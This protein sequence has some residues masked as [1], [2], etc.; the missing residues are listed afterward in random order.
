MPD[1]RKHPKFRSHQTPMNLLLSII[2]VSLLVAYSQVIV[3]WRASSLS[4]H[5]LT[6]S[7]LV[8]M[9]T[10]IFSDP[11]ILSGYVAGF[12]GSIAWLFV[13][14]RLALAVAFPIYIGMTFV[15]VIACSALFLGEPLNAPKLVAGAL[16]LAGIAVGSRA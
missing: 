3:K 7:T 15:A 13:V 8:G 14:S 11:F 12:V 10:R 6:D 2:P 5:Q 16:I 9:L 4:V 1:A